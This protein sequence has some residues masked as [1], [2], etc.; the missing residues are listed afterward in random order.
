LTI[1]L[2]NAT[3]LLR[4]A[5]IP[6]IGAA[7][8]ISVLLITEAWLLLPARYPTNWKRFH[9]YG[10]PIECYNNRGAQG[11]CMLVNPNCPYH[12]HHLPS[13]DSSF[14]QYQLSF[15]IA[16]T[17]IHRLHLPPSLDNQTALEILSF[18]PS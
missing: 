18:L 15:T 9:T 5:I 14:V 7:Q 13:R 16:D 12:I 17:L 3:D 11:I 10:I 8:P 1:T 4:H 2:F 6:I